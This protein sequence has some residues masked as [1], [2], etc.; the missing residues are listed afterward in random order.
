MR[1]PA[2]GIAGLG[3]LWVPSD[4]VVGVVSLSQL[5]GVAVVLGWELP[6]GN[7][8]PDCHALRTAILAP[9]SAASSRELR[10][11]V[12]ASEGHLSAQSRQS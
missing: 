3:L 6:G 4:E 5:A 12:Q 9:V 11:V 1:V 2:D 8:V 10:A 7:V